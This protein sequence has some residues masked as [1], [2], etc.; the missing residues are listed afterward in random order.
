MA[1][2]ETFDPKRYAPFTPGMRSA[3]MLSTFPAID[4]QQVAGVHIMVDAAQAGHRGNAQRPGQD[5]GMA[6]RPAMF[7]DHTRKTVEVHGKQVYDRC[8]VGHEDELF[9]ALLRG[10]RPWPQ[11]PQPCRQRTTIRVSQT[12]SMFPPE[13][14]LPY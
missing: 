10:R 13:Y 6:L 8:L 5:G 4:S 12:S 11:M 7:D 2:T 9:A 3:D 14:P 1:H